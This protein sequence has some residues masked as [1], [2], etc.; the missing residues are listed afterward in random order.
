MSKIPSDGS[1][2]RQYM[3]LLPKEQARHSVYVGKYV[4]ILAKIIHSDNLC[5][6]EMETAA[7]LLFG[8]AAYY[9]DIGKAWVPHNILLKPEKLT[10]KEVQI[11]HMHPLFAEQIFDQI[12]SRAISGMP[13]ELIHLARESALYHHEW[14]NGKGYPYGLSKEEIPFIARITS[15]C[16]IYDAITSDRAYRKAHSH[17]FACHEIERSAGN[18]LDPVLAQIFLDNHSQFL[19]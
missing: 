6:G 2:V 14:W 5:R 18:Q 1:S 19:I 11:V 4:G 16:D 3:Q 13:P 17:D 8:N 9:H 7:Y 12:D 10:E 15:V